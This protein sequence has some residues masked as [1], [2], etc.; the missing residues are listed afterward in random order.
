[1]RNKDSEPQSC[2]LSTALAKTFA[3]AKHLVKVEYD[4]IVR[5]NLIKKDRL[6][7]TIK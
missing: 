5:L 6:S 1:M 4:K 2:G 3:L 7:D